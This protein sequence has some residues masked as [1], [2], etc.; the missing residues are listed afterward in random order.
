[1]LEQEHRRP[2]IAFDH[3]HGARH[4]Q[5]HRSRRDAV[6]KGRGWRKIG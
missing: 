5:R 6:G 4:R 2:G 1:M 3:V